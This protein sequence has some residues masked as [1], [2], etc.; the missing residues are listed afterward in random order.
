MGETRQ[1]IDLT[2]FKKAIDDMIIKSDKSWNESLGYSF[3]TRRLKEYTKEEI[4]NIINSGS[5][6][7]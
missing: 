4:E 7:A 1:E 3:H 2:T 5:L 6:Q